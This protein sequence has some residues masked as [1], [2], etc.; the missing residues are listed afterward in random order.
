MRLTLVFLVS[1]GY[2]RD[3]DILGISD[4]TRK[5][6]GG[7]IL[8]GG[9]ANRTDYRSG[10]V[11]SAL[12]VAVRPEHAC[13]EIAVVGPIALPPG[14]GT[15]VFLGMRRGIN[16]QRRRARVS[17]ALNAS[18]DA[19]RRRISGCDLRVECRATAPA[20]RS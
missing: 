9:G 6:A 17:H 15:P 1:P 4:S 8:G 3:A 13:E 18:T 5:A 20:A 16:P 7:L 2:R 10:R 11:R 19:D 14:I 12:A